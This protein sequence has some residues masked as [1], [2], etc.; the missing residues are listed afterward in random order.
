MC[1]LIPLL[2][3]L[4]RAYFPCEMLNG[5]ARILPLPAEVAAQIK[6]SNTIS[7]LNHA[8]YGLLENSLDAGARKI[9]IS[10]DF[11]R[12]ACTVEDDGH[13]IA[14]TEFSVNGGLG[15]LYRELY[16]LS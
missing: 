13:G 4:A 2:L 6:S 1:L 12:G 3:L 8:V 15:K 7:S 11:L 14:P 16:C 10:V 5:V 9:D